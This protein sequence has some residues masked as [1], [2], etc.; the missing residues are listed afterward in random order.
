MVFQVKTSLSQFFDRNLFERIILYLFIADLLV[1]LIFEFGFGQSSLGQS[2]NKQW[3]FY[4]L[5]GLDYLISMKKC[6]NIRITV[7]PLSLFSLVFFIMIAQGL[8]IGIINNNPKFEMLNDTVP[9]LMIALN[10]LRMQSY[11]EHARPI[12]FRFLLNVVSTLALFSCMTG[13]ITGMIG[14]NATAII[15]L[16]P[17]YFPL[18]FA[19]LFV[20]KPFPRWAAFVFVIMIALSI[21]EINR[22]SM[23]FIGL[24]I[25]G[26]AVFR[27]L[28]NPSQ[29]LLFI[30]GA[31]IL[32]STTWLVLP[33]NSK[34]YRRIVGLTQLDLST[35]KGAVGERAAEFD[36]ISAS[37]A[38]RGKNP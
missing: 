29:G 11:G 28:K 26:Y 25:G 14:R 7:N 16:A 30:I 8:F 37:L 33:E 20:V 3:I 19:G 2:Q 31:T 23:A 22:S 12:D 1:K 13:F 32:L 10:I 35:R 15:P 6:L 38:K 9:L 36:S 27:T 4:T 24:A 18:A 5:L 17:I 34:T 21:S